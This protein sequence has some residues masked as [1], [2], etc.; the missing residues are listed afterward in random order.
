MF[1]VT[2]A[3]VVVSHRRKTA[4]CHHHHLA[5]PTDFLLGRFTEGFD[6]NLR[7]LLDIIRMKL[8]E[9]LDDLRRLAR[10]NIGV[11]LSGLGYTIASTVGHIVL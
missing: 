6:D 3:F 1:D 7:L 2:L 5:A 11:I 9:L 10:R 8:L 4:A